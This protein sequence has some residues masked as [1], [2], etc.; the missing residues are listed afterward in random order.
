M[1]LVILFFLNVLPLVSIAQLTENLSFST[2]DSLINSC[3]SKGNFKQAIVYME[4]AQTQARAALGEQDSVYATYTDGLGFFNYMAGQYQKAEQLYLEAID[5]KKKIFGAKNPKTAF[6]WDNL[7]LLYVKIEKFEQAETIYKRTKKIYL[8]AYGAQHE[9]YAGSLNNLAALYERSRK[10]EAAEQYY[11]QAGK[12]WRATLGEQHPRYALWLNNL[13]VVYRR[14]RKFEEAEPL[15]LQALAIREQVFGVQHRIYARS[16]GSIAQ[17]YKDMGN[18]D[19]A[20]YYYLKAQSITEQTIGVEHPRYAVIL[21]NLAILY[22]EKKE[23]QK[24]LLLLQKSLA[25]NEKFYGKSS[26]KYGGAL[27]NLA[28]L[29]TKMQEYQKAE[30]LYWKVKKLWKKILSKEDPLHGL[31]WYNLAHLYLQQE[32]LDTAFAYAMTGI[33][34]NS[35]NFKAIFPSAFRTSNKAVTPYQPQF[36]QPISPL[37]DLL[38]LVNLEFKQLVEANQMIRKLIE[39][40]KKKLDKAPNQAE[41][42]QYFILIKVGM[43]VNEKIRNQFAGKQ[44]KLRILDQNTWLVREG[45]AAAI[46]LNRTEITREAFAFS[47]QNKSILLAD[48]IKGNRAKIMGDLPDSLV[49]RELDLQT[50]KTELKKAYYEAKTTVEKDQLLVAENL[51]NQKIDAF[52]KKIKKDYPRYHQLKYKNITAQ[53]TEVQALLTDKSILLEYFITDTVTYLFVVS[54]DSIRLL[55]ISVSKTKLK[56][57][58]KQFHDALSNYNRLVKQEEEAYALYTQQAYWFYKTL[59]AEAL[60]GTDSDQLI[61]VADGELGHLP[62]E[63]FLSKDVCQQKRLY[64]DLPYLL[65][66]Y[67]ICY[68]YSATLWKENLHQEVPINNHQILACAAAYPKQYIVDSTLLQRRSINSLNWR[69]GLSPL[70]AAQKEVKHLSK[71]FQ[72]KFIQGMACNEAC[73][74]QESGKYGVIHL[75]MHGILHPRVPMLSSLAFTEN[76]DSLED[77]FLQAYEIARLNLNADLV[78]LSACETGYGEFKQGEGIISLARSFMYAGTPSLV[79]SLWQVNDHSTSVIMTYFYNYLAEGMP[80]DQALR[81]AKLDYIA[82]TTTWAAHPAFWSPFIQ[83]GDNR[84]IQLT[85]PLDWFPWLIGVGIFFLVL[86]FVLKRKKVAFEK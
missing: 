28:A 54:K 22:K 85:Q 26:L 86:V 23:Y 78:V 48:A 17:L 43:M 20:E 2:L 37:D 21:N 15:Y 70:P 25:I 3:Y 34:Q 45:I 29:Y 31:V 64:K 18:Y 51:L 72:G 62:F 49:F 66:D 65:N 69:K 76:K 24:A 81:Q 38:K 42:K 53:A 55:P 16:L 58:I 9:E 41:W 80:K 68:N 19:R 75:A 6:A 13:A 4:Q 30:E 50:Q 44:N 32:R 46:A 36:Y 10:Y 57:N 35:T 5:I 52:L 39:I 59:I 33:A 84:P 56:Q 7:A 77:N 79:V 82:M 67:S 8:D 71:E 12:I 73:F 11:L 74:K 61:I 63:A 83:L 14:M 27:N 40:T 47:E 1:R 60:E